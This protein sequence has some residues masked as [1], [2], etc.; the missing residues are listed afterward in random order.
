MGT[1]TLYIAL[2]LDGYIAKP[3]GS[4][5]WLSMV[6][7]EGED[8][9]YADFYADMDALLMGR[10]TYEQ[11]LTFG[12]WPYPD[13]PT[14]VITGRELKAGPEPVH[15]LP[16][17]DDLL[18]VITSLKQQY[19]K[20]WLV[21][22]GQLATSLHQAGLIDQYQLFL[23]PVTLGSGIPLFTGQ[24]SQQQLDLVDSRHHHSGL[25]ALNYCRVEQK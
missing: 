7:E 14:Y 12:D 24:S 9:G 1:V 13:K 22:G 11:I 18:P 6:E 2:S 5:D 25:V 17:G 19:E 3:D 15:R 16:T 20:L 10:K 8:Y 23:V 4:V 21:G